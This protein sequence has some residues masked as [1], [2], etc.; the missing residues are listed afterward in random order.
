MITSQTVIADGFGQRADRD[1]FLIGPT[2]LA[3][4]P[5][6][7]LYVSDALGNRIVAIPDATTRTTSAGTGRVV[8]KDGLLQRPLAL[9]LTRRTAICWPAT[10]TNGQVVEIDP[11]PA[12][13]STRNGST[14]TR[15]SRR[16]ATAIC[17]ASR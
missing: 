16:P 7:T 14:P 1:V 4:A 5:D 2:G 3:L 17:S 11:Q 9:V 13:S 12:S 6:N 15:R 8:T 10:R